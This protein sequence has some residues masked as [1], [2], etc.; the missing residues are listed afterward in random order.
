ML[1][2]MLLYGI[3]I[4]V[5]VN[6]STTATTATAATTKTTTGEDSTRCI[7]VGGGDGQIGS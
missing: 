5:V 6:A 3:E 1:P 2:L 4:L 7:P